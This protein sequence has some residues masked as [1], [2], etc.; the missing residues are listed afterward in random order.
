MGYLQVPN[1][2]GVINRPG[3]YFSPRSN[4][5]NYPG[6]SELVARDYVDAN[7]ETGIV[8]AGTGGNVTAQR[9][10]GGSSPDVWSSDDTF[11]GVGNPIR[12]SAKI[13]LLG[14]S[15]K[16]IGLTDTE[17][18]TDQNVVN[19]ALIALGTGQGFA[20]WSRE[21]GDN[22][23]DVVS[24]TTYIADDVISIEYDPIDSGGSIIF[25]KNG[26]EVAD[27]KKT[28]VGT[29]LNLKGAVTNNPATGTPS[30][31]ELKIWT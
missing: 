8:I 10:A 12:I 31:G 28:G 18:P 22:G 26:V 11:A 14:S 23:T 19:F 3:G 20:L 15:A 4:G 29:S 25:K 9:T 17:T 16:F 1:H 13:L 21:D 5:T 7:P 2:I 27:L 30:H 24:S 6:V